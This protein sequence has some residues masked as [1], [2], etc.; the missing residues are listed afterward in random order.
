MTKICAWCQKE[1]VIT[2]LEAHDTMAQALQDIND[3]N[4]SHGICQRHAAEA[5]DAFYKAK[6]KRDA[7]PIHE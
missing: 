3:Q 7:K 6:E 4:V 1:G 5:M 2:L